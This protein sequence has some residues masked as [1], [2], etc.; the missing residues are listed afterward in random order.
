MPTAVP[1]DDPFSTGFSG[2]F[3]SEEIVN[4]IRHAEIP[5]RVSNLHSI[6]SAL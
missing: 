1:N 3:T 5:H 2:F 6:L 4:A